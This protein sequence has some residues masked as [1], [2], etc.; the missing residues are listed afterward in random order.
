MEG[1][2]RTNYFRTGGADPTARSGG[3][4]YMSFKIRSADVDELK[5]TR[6]LYEIFVHSS[7][8]EGIHLRGAPVS[9]GGI[10][11]SDRPDDFR[12]EV[13]GLVTT[14]MVKNA[15]IVPNGSKGGFI[16]RKRFDDRDQMGAEAADQYRTLMRGM[17]DITDNLVDGKVVPPPGVVRHDGDDPYLVVAADKGTAHLSDVANGV[18]A[19]YGFWLDDAFASAADPTATTTR[20]KG[21]RRAADGSAC[22]RHFREMGKDIQKEPF[23]VAG[24]GDMSGDVFGNGMLLS[25]QIKLLAAFDHR[26]IFIDPD[27]DPAVSFEERQRVFNL[28]RSSWEDYDRSKLSAGAHHRPPRLQGGGADAGGPRALGLADEVTVLDGES[29]IRAVL[30]APVELLWNGGIGTYVKDAEETHA[31]VGDPTND[32]VRVNAEDLR[33]KV[34]GEGGN[35]G[36]TQ[37]ARIQFHLQRRAHQHRRAGQLRRRGHERPRGEPQDPAEPG[38]ARRRPDAESATRCCGR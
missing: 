4:P 33:C 18:A 26:H 3:V 2:V 31:E 8:M 27:P 32:P 7:R 5:K 6:L 24:I 21:S 36:L 9:R 35:L 19:E 34:I 37:R 13:L 15:V 14:Q 1:T 22:K 23:T 10:R 28:P 38:G 11:W 30:T 17:L 29:L 25:Q 12:T 16:T 20:R